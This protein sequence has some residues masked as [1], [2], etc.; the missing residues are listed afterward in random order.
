MSN[1]LIFAYRVFARMK[2]F[3]SRQEGIAMIMV[4]AFM[5]LSVPMITA[6]LASSSSL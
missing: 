6:A 1:Y 3:V 4:I 5:A 2:R